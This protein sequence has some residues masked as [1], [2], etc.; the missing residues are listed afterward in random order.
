MFNKE[1][2]KYIY[3]Q[4]YKIYI[5][6]L[7][8]DN[9]AETFDKFQLLKYNNIDEWDK[10]KREYRTIH[11][12]H[13]KP[14]NDSFKQSAITSYYDF[15]KEDIEMTC[16]ALSRYLPRSQKGFYK[17]EDIVDICHNKDYNY[18]E[19][20]DGDIKFVK[21]YNDIAII[22]NNLKEEVVSIVR[23]KNPKKG[24]GNYDN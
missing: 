1:I 18:I 12:I 24:W 7:G 15:L 11:E 6:I 2:K 13:K 5:S 22:Y 16:H 8:K 9:M 19:Q 3:I 23:R 10:K 4:Q 14:W 17:F 21:Y 20:D